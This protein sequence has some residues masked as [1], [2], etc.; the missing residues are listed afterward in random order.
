MP[1]LCERIASKIRA[2]YPHPQG[3]QGVGR[4]TSP[5]VE[6]DALPQK[7]ERGRWEGTTGD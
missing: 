7:N 2:L 5:S 4:D 1:H 6:E 3:A